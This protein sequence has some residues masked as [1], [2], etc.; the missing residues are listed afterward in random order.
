VLTARQT[1]Y[2]RTQRLAVWIG[3]PLEV[4]TLLIGWVVLMRMVPWP[5]MTDSAHQIARIYITRRNGI[6]FGTILAGMGGG[7]MTLWLAVLCLHIRRSEGRWG[8]LSLAELLFAAAIPL[9]FL[10]PATTQLIAAYE[11]GRLPAPFIKLM[12][13][14]SVTF[15]FQPDYTF[16]PELLLMAYAVYTSTGENRVFPRWLGHLSFVAGLAFIA[17]MFSNFVMKG[18]LAFNGVLGY[19]IPVAAFAVWVIAVTVALLQ[20]I[21]QEEAEALADAN[22]L[23]GATLVP[24]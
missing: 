10:V 16:I 23:D 9:E 8:P 18:A 3:G 21:N 17:P 19:W 20:A 12:H 7:L 4:V 11:A 22:T 2:F 6:M 5:P 24:A 14:L 13:D 15:W 1:T